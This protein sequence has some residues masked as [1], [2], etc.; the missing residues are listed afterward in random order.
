MAPSV[1]T[2]KLENEILIRCSGC[3]SILG[4][5][6][7]SDWLKD[8]AFP[9]TMQRLAMNH[10]CASCDNGKPSKGPAEGTLVAADK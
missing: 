2:V 9:R 3:G 4:R 1:E 6:L 8:Q 10:Q 7:F 5:M